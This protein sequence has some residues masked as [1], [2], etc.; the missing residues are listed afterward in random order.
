[1]V[2][3]R[4]A[5]CNSYISRTSSTVRSQLQQS[6]HTHAAVS[7]TT[8]YFLNKNV[9][10]QGYRKPSGRSRFHACYVKGQDMDHSGDLKTVAAVR[11]KCSSS[12]IAC[13][14]SKHLVDRPCMCTAIAKYTATAQY[15]PQLR[16]QHIGGSQGGQCPPSTQRWWRIGGALPQPWPRQPCPQ[17]SWSWR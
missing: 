3:N 10:D 7:S 9:R 17:T 13:Q 12:D 14:R 1:M 2:H 11:V 6:K 8:G 5:E 16:S 15:V 4:G